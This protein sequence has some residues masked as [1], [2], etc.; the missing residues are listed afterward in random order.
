[1]FILSRIL[2]CQVLLKDE[3]HMRSINCNIVR[4]IF[5]FQ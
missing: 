3:A 5:N 1:M 4:E 2:I